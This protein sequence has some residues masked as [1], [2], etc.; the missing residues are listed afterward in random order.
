[1]AK[2][3]AVIISLFS[4]VCFSCGNITSEFND[5][6]DDD[7]DYYYAINATEGDYSISFHSVQTGG[8]GTYGQMIRDYSEG[9]LA[10]IVK[11]SE[12]C[13]TIKSNLTDARNIT[14]N[15]VYFEIT[16]PERTL[17][18]IGVKA[19]YSGAEDDYIGT[20][21]PIGLTTFSVSYVP[22]GSE[23]ETSVSQ[24]SKSSFSAGALDKTVTLNSPVT[25][26]KVIIKAIMLKY[27]STYQESS[28][29]YDIS[30][31]RTNGKLS[32]CKVILE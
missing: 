31:A 27:Y 32:L 22:S 16:F 17:T 18:S 7:T 23:T 10:T 12:D 20:D 26:S 13:F 15:Q 21:S 29:Y 30:T 25:T 5:I 8:Y 14:T 3:S 1:M 2:I 6:E 9:D 19:A 24:I 4:L 28:D 11:D